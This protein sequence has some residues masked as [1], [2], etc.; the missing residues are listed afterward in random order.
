MNFSKLPL[1]V[2]SEIKQVLS[3]FDECSV[4]QNKADDY[5]INT[6][7]VLHTGDYNKF[8]GRYKA[9]DVFTV[10][11]RIINY[12]KEF[13]DFP[14]GMGITYKGKKD[15]KMLNSNWKDVVMSDNGDLEFIM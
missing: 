4:E 8:I 3:A 15:W 9:E 2:Q 6:S 10:E 1:N 5:E 7:T 11:E 14:F 13:R 12:V